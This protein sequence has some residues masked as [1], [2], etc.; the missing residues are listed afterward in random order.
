MTKSSNDNEIFLSGSMERKEDDI[1]FIIQMVIAILTICQ[2]KIITN[3][4][5]QKHDNR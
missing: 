2:G 4:H 3:Q 5:G 1:M